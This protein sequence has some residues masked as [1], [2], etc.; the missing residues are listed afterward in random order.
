M[1]ESSSD[2]ALGKADTGS[3]DF[4]E[5]VTLSHRYGQVGRC[6]SSVT[7]D[8]NNFL[9]AIMAYAELIGL[10]ETLSADAQGMV[11][12]I[13]GA[14]RKSSSLI[15]NLTDVARRDRPDVRIVDPGAVVERALDLQR[16]DLKTAHIDVQSTSAPD[17]PPIP[18]DL[19]R[20]QR[21]I[22]ALILNAKEAVEGKDV[23]EIR[24]TSGPVEAETENA[25][26]NG[27]L[28]VAIW[29]SGPPIAE[30][31]R[32]RVFEPFFTTKGEDHL[33]LGLSA[34]RATLHLH[35][36]ELTYCPE[37]GFV[38]RMPKFNSLSGTRV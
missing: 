30:D 2:G 12:E 3:N 16:Y 31:L 37:R 18:V 34:A 20:L 4:R 22:M 19:P 24:V 21:A 13:V 6:V 7:H 33:G 1:T 36:G 10:D 25:E 26:G 17:L 8:V 28:E 29:N 27:L 5:R 15:N 11:E 35:D 9:G 32:E 23:R 38:A 14:V